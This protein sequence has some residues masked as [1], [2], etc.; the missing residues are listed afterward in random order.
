MKLAVSMPAWMA[1]LATQKVA[2]MGYP[3]F[4]AYIQA[5]VH[6]DT[7]SSQ[8]HVRWARNHAPE[9]AASTPRPQRP[10]RAKA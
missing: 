3:T 10:R 2:D 8:P 5:L 7:S 1:E 6:S 9:P 4:S